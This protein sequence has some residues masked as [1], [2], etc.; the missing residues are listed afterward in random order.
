MALL[1][2]KNYL[3]T[4]SIDTEADA[5]VSLRACSI[6]INAGDGFIEAYAESIN[7]LKREWETSVDEYLA[8]C[9]RRDIS[10][11]K[12]YS[13]K[14]MMRL[15]PELH[16]A[17]AACAAAEG[18]SLNA[19]LINAVKDRAQQEAGPTQKV[20]GRTKAKRKGARSTARKPRRVAA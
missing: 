5:A 13:G 10:P 2:Y 15:D 12:P 7:D 18:V 14:L 3:A 1:R 6:N 20:R 16:G 4:V 11:A 9:K 19:W 8:F 17:V